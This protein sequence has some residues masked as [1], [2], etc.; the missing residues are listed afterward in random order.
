MTAIPLTPTQA[1]SIAR[2]VY[3]LQESGIK[4]ALADGFD[5]GTDGL[6][7]IESGTQFKGESG[8]LMFKKMTG[9]GYLA[10]GVGR[11]Q[12]ELLIATRGTAIG[13]DW[14][15]N[16]NVG[17]QKGP[18]GH[19]VH[20][21]FHEVWKSFREEL[22][23]FVRNRNFSHVHC[24]GHSL[25]GA[26]AG[27]NADWSSSAGIAKTSLYTFGAP[28]IGLPGFSEALTARL[29]A[30]SIFRV[31]HVADVVPMIPIFPFR[32]APY[33]RGG[34]QTR[35]GNGLI[36]KAAHIMKTSYIPGVLD[37]GWEDLA[38]ED[39]DPTTDDKIKRWVES[40]ADSSGPAHMSASVLGMI[41][42]ALNWLI[43]QAGK[44]LVG[45]LG[46]TMAIGATVLDQL[47]WLLSRAAA[48]S[49]IIG[50]HLK[51]LMAAVFRF[52]G[53]T[54]ASTAEMTAS[55]L[56]WALGLL[57]STLQNVATRTLT[58]VGSV[59]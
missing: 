32:H 20:A 56:R 19:L 57:W 45:A 41:A 22:H 2:G 43:R 7:G 25:G 24:V 36:G 40:S 11:R 17:M 21:G 39:D 48:V 44:L 35:N 18:S 42:R 51:A 26:L 47:A 29:K 49:D 27:L 9:F 13:V 12:G 23:S 1:A 15:S 30:D 50:G 33:S 37:R 59:F 38:N 52:L 6:F 58:V 14:L 4:D 55:F 31:S 28:R 54:I 5:L 16:L 3:L 34:Y 53:R 8:G 10:T 46:T